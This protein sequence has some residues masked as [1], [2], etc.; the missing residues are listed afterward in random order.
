M[1]GTVRVTRGGLV[2]SSHRVHAV[3]TEGDRPL[4]TLGDPGRWTFYRSA[5]KPF[6]ALPL[7]EDGVLAALGFGSE[8]LALACASH[9]AEPRH[10]EVA[11]RMRDALDISDDDLAC[12][13]HWPLRDAAALRLLD[14]GRAPGRLDNNCSGK[15]LGMIA[16]ALHHGWEV[17][18][19]QEPAHPVQAR[20]R[21]ETA[22][23]S[24]VDEGRLR[25]GVDGCGVVCFAVPL[26]DMARSFARFG[27]GGEAAAE[28]L[29]AMTAHPYLVA[30]SGRLCS[31][32]M[33]A[34]PDVVAKVGAEGVYGACV[35]E[36]G[37]GIAIKVED[38]GWRAVDAVLVA[39]L[40]HLG[41]LTPAA[42]EALD[43]YL[44]PTLRNTRGEVVGALEVDLGIEGRGP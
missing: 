31:D 18:G 36:A 32:L 25:T 39:L 12:G 10:L 4:V 44:R 41:L 17:A 15:H 21:R 6:Q 35:P 1:T 5:A 8:E 29:R 43:A 19:Y 24:G 7:V 14:E 3:V 22:R 38:G 13:P 26:L 33:T 2:E 23:W 11:A 42:R 34:A 37:L 20:M 16:L 9:S 40:G 30:G 28:V 27:R